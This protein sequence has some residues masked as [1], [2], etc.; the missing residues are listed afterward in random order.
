MHACVHLPFGEVAQPACSQRGCGGMG[1]V[2]PAA[3]IFRYEDWSR[4][5]IWYGD[6]HVA[7]KGNSDFEVTE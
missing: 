3:R 7:A 4:S 6:S 1:R 2:A 5:S